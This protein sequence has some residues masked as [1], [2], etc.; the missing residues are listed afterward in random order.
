METKYYTIYE[1]AQLLNIHHFTVRRNIERGNLKAVKIGNI[2]RIAES[3][4]QAFLTKKG[5]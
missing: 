3:D 5:V 1:V 2:Y 4:L